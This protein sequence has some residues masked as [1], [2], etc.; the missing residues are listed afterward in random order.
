MTHSA[1]PISVRA[2]S[3]IADILSKT[4]TAQQALDAGLL[5][6]CAVLLNE[7]S[8]R[9]LKIVL[10][11]MSNI[12][13]E[14][15]QIAALVMQSGLVQVALFRCRDADDS[16]FKECCFALGNLA[17]EGD[18]AQVACLVSFGAFDFFAWGLETR[19]SEVVVAAISLFEKFFE[20]AR[21]P[22]SEADSPSQAFVRERGIST[23]LKCCEHPSPEV[24][25]KADN[26]LQAYYSDQSELVQMLQRTHIS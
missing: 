13:V 8:N 20:A 2:V 3:V 19:C 9:H 6:Q 26:A 11:I 7:V 17:N 10:F 24:N 18:F 15:P 12:S 16:I 23:L 21:M 5:T 14:S 22:V 1:L 4:V 25:V